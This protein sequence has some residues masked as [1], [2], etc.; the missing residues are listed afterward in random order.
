MFGTPSAV[1]SIGATA[2]D[3]FKAVASSDVEWYSDATSND[4]L[5]KVGNYTIKYVIT[6][7]ADG[8]TFEKTKTLSVKN[9][10]VVP[11]VTVSSRTVDTL[12]NDDIKKV[13]VTNVDMNNNDGDSSALTDIVKTG[14]AANNK[15]TVKSALVKDTYH[16]VT[17][18]FYVPINT[19][20]KTE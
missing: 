3:E 1:A 8:K 18:T 13:L 20:F 7:A 2:G 6:K 4:T 11:K 17:W 16:D 5:A 12:S 14:T 9:S 15:V 10:I 19:T